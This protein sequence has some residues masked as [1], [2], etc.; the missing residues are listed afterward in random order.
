MQFLNAI[1]RFSV[2]NLF[3]VPS[4]RIPV[5][6]S[7]PMRHARDPGCLFPSG[8]AGGD[9]AAATALGIPITQ[10]GRA[11]NDVSGFVSRRVSSALSGGFMRPL[12]FADQV[13]YAARSHFKT[14]SIP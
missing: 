12:S 14:R 6:G 8:P 4:F 11:V 3:H 9:A 5:C 7:Q 1:N 13:G 10:G 2:G